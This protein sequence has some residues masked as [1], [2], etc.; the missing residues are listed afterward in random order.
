MGIRKAQTSIIRFTGLPQP[1]IYYEE[2]HASVNSNV[3]CYYRSFFF[4]DVVVREAIE[5]ICLHSL[6]NAVQRYNFILI[7]Q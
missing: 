7:Q 3:D 2:I 5:H 4:Y 1:T 6:Q